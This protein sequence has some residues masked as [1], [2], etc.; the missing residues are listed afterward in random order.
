MTRV[1]ISSCTIDSGHPSALVNELL[2]EGFEVL[3]S[4]RKGQR[5]NWGDW[6]NRDS[7]NA[8]D[9]TDI[10]IIAVTENWQFSTWMQHEAREAQKRLRTGRIQKML[11]YNPE[12]IVVTAK[13][14]LPFLNQ[15]LPDEL[16]EVAQSLRGI[17][18]PD[19]I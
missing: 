10:F 14:M 17:V 7:L 15:R 4:P 19:A 6:Y 1:F 18:A 2:A 16:E 9:Q 5:V 8:L 3:H 11:F 12:N 13:G